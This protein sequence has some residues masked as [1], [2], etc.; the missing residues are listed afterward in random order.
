MR[1]FF[2]GLV[3]GSP[4][5]PEIRLPVPGTTI[6]LNRCPGWLTRLLLSWIR[7]GPEAEQ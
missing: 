3:F 1:R 5:G 2:N 7:L 4:E 6:Q